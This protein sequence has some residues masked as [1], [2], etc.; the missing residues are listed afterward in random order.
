M[1]GKAKINASAAGKAGKATGKAMT[2]A[3]SVTA[4]E[5]AGLIFS[6]GRS[7]R[8]LRQGRYADRIGRTGAVFMAGV[9]EYLCNEFM[10]L[11]GN[12]AKE[13]NAVIIQPRDIG[14]AIRNDDELTKLCANIQFTEGGFSSNVN[15]FLFPQKNKKGGK[16]LYV[17]Q[18][19]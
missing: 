1:A 5:R 8:Y 7:M 17:T 4:H 6:V 15:E 13:R 14:K 2:R 3:K 11:A 19:M 16:A 12:V 18:E 10:E 9:L